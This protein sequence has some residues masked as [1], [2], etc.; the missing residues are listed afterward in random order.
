MPLHR[1]ELQLLLLA[2][3]RARLGE[4]AVRLDRA[5]E[6]WEE[7]GGQVHAR[8]RSRAGETHQASGSCSLKQT[9]PNRPV[10]QKL[11]A[12]LDTVAASELDSLRQRANS[13]IMATL[14]RK[15]PAKQTP[16][17]SSSAQCGWPASRPGS[18]AASKASLANTLASAAPEPDASA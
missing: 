8:F 9:T 10:R 7:R 5:L 15:M 13:A 3:A 18:M 6:G 1:G 14:E 12:Q 17:A 2:A 4:Q 16:R 11:A